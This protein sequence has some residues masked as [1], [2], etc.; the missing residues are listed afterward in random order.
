MATRPEIGSLATSLDELARRVSSLAE[1]AQH[2]DEELAG[3][4]FG[5]ERALSGALRRLKKL[6]DPARR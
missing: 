1:A 2:Q 6:S 3:E 5:I 4:L